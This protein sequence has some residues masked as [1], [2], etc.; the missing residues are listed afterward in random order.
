MSDVNV[1]LHRNILPGKE[2]DKLIPKSSCK[3][4]DAGTG[5][6][7]LSINIMVEVVNE[8]SWQMQ[9]VADVLEKSSLKQTID[10]IHSFEYNHFQYNADLNDQFI[11]SSAC[12]WFQRVSGID[13][14][15]YS[16]IA[17]SILLE[18]EISH[19]IRKT[20]YDIT[21]P[22]EFTHVYV[23]VPV[24]QK[25]YNLNKGY[26][27]ID[28]TIEE[29]IEPFAVNKKDQFMSGLKHY[30]LN[31]YAGLNSGPDDEPS[32]GSSTSS[33]ASSVYHAAES[34]GWFKKISLKN[35][36]GGLKTPIGCW[37]GT[38]YSAAVV[39]AD[40][41]SLATYSQK[42][43]NEMN[44]A[45]QAN[46]MQLFSE[47]ANEYEGMVSLFVLCVYQKMNERS[48]NSCSRG[49]LISCG[50]AVL[51]YQK[52]ILG[53]LHAWLDEYFTNVVIGS[54]AYN[55]NMV[56]TKNALPFASWVSPIPQWSVPFEKFTKKTPLPVPNFQPTE[57]TYSLI[58]TPG[59]FKPEDY[60]KGFQQIYGVIQNPSTIFTGSSTSGGTP[61]ITTSGSPVLTQ[62]TPKTPT[63]SNAGMGI[64]GFLLIGG[65]IFYGMN[66]FSNPTN[67]KK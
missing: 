48:W 36:I 57:Y 43:L 42:A 47:K 44:D 33:T 65:A 49:N 54:R 13:C 45:L 4:T 41:D 27:I 28:G 32:G 34:S 55:G 6:T 1:L 38:A 23:V 10:A 66:A 17:S 59:A 24:D 11:R 46:D 63:T 40:I 35:I 56:H 53:S 12:S 5:F 60:I 61:P 62:T 16:I 58:K 64:V 22:N 20:S 37:G 31:G 51:F 9:D 52:A 7:D 3:K 14:K 67:A 39:T 29:N 21:Q 30:V 25:T 8:Y 15:S 2:F 26:Y 50:E 18:L 19:Y